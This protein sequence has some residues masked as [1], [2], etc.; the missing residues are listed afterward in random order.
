[1]IDIPPDIRA[2]LRAC[3]L[4]LQQLAPGPFGDAGPAVALRERHA[5]ALAA[6]QD[7]LEQHPG[8]AA[9]LGATFDQA[10]SHI[11]RSVGLCYIAFPLEYGPRADLLYQASLLADMADQSQIDPATVARVQAALARDIAWLAEF[12]AGQQP[13]AW[14]GPQPTALSDVAARFLAELLAGL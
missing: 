7:G 14:P 8:L 2:E 5:A 1:M 13:P 6:A 10:V 3:W 9:E 4:S 12:H 11:E